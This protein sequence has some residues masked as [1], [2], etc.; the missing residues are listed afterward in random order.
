MCWHP[1]F[2]WDGAAVAEFRETDKARTT[3]VSPQLSRAG[4]FRKGELVDRSQCGFW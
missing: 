3:P 4:S 2:F 1:R